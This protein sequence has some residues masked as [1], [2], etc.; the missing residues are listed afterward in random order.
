[1]INSRT[2]TLARFAVSASALCLGLLLACGG[3][4]ESS[5]GDDGGS[6]NGGDGGSAGIGGNGGIGGDGGSGGTPSQ[7]PSI[8]PAEGSGCADVDMVCSYANCS[9]PDY[10]D[11]HVLQCTDGAWL[12]VGTEPCTAPEECP[13]YLYLG[14]YCGPPESQGPCPYYDACGDVHDAYCVDHYWQPGAAAEDAAPPGGGGASS[15]AATA[16]SATI[17]TGPPPVQC[18]AYPPY[19]GSACCPTNYPEFCDYSESGSDSVT[20]TQT[21]FGA[22]NG[23]TGPATSGGAATSGGIPP[24]LCAVCTS[25]MIWEA[26][27]ER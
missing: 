7:C 11:G 18:P 15:A 25:Q 8:E 3:T 26:C 13:P 2:M 1:M 10:R 12:L 24:L 4:T 23:G 17:T 21:S 19:Q 16:I 9:A 14:S 6:N 27:P 5:H 20:S 22:T